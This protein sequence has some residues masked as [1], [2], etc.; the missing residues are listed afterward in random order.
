MPEFSVAIKDHGGSTLAEFV[1]PTRLTYEFNIGANGPGKMSF[2]LAEADPDLSPSLFMPKLADYELRMDGVP[3]QA[4]FIDSVNMPLGTDEIH[5]SGLD[6][7]EWL[8]QPWRYYYAPPMDYD[9]VIDLVIATDDATEFHLVLGPGSQVQDWVYAILEPLS[10]DSGE[11]VILNPIISGGTFAEELVGH[12]SRSSGRTGLSLL[13]ELAGM[14]DPYGFDFWA[15]PN[16]NLELRGP[17][18]TDPE[19]VVPVATM[20]ESSGSFDGSSFDVSP[21]IDGDWTN[22]GPAGTDI[23]FLDG[24]GNAARYFRKQHQPSVDQF[25]R[26]GA[27]VTVGSRDP[28][29]IGTQTESEFKAAA[30]S[31]RMMF[32]QR[33]LTLQVKPELFTFEQYLMESVDVDYQKFPGSFRRIDA[34]FWITKQAY[35]ETEPGSGDWVCDL[36]LDQIYI[37]I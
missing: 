10:E 17:R 25:R 23:L 20:T 29:T 22:N 37:P 18:S 34:Y 13:Q 7:L 16:K 33:E 24:I 21:I 6:W 15:R 28:F 1:N 35:S 26:W 31:Y 5:V 19:A 14:G 3:I 11:Q 8:N 9:D 12:L 4:G 27:D 30:S 32:P 36:S 2:S